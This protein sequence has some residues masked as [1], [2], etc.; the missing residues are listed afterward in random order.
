MGI[1]I[2]DENTTGVFTAKADGR[3]RILPRFPP[4][5]MDATRRPPSSAGRTCRNGRFRC[6]RKAR[7]AVSPATHG[8][9]PAVP[10]RSSGPGCAEPRAPVRGR[11][12]RTH[13]TPHPS[14]LSHACRDRSSRRP[15]ARR[16]R[17]CHPATA[18]PTPRCGCTASIRTATGSPPALTYGQARRLAMNAASNLT[19]MPPTHS[20][21]HCL[22]S[23]EVARSDTHGF[24]HGG[25]ETALFLRFRLHLTVNR[26]IR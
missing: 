1:R 16:S 9:P 12:A 2:G 25:G 13:R 5:P 17:S 4:S 11:T 10:R 20:K 19:S 6:H 3:S 22:A 23:S 8:R 14:R 15:D 21:K 26:D 18:S 7:V 24:G